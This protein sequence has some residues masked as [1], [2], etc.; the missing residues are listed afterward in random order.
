LLP[1]N[2][3]EKHFYT[4]LEQCEVL[5]GYLELGGAGLSVTGPIRDIGQ[6]VLQSAFV[7]GS[8]SNHSYCHISFLIAFF[9]E[10]LI[11]NIIIT[12]KVNYEI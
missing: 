9:E 2:T 4:N 10:E 11:R 5:I 8:C 7:T 12:L 6:N 1:D 3:A